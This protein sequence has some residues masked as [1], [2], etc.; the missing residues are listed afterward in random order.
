M[1]NVGVELAI[2]QGKPTPAIYSILIP[3]VVCYLLYLN[4]KSHQPAKWQKDKKE[5]RDFN[6]M[7]LEAKKRREERMN[8]KKKINA[9]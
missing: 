6:T 2:I 5:N 1:A 8:N 9:E 7:R 3:I 4:Y